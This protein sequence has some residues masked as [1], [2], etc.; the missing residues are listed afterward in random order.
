MSDTEIL[1]P[2][3]QWYLIRRGSEEVKERRREKQ[4]VSC[5]LWHNFTSV[6]RGVLEKVE[7]YV[8][9]TRERAESSNYEE[10]FL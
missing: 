1:H 5:L 6:C 9:K 10:K 8:T 4:K 2:A 3:G 7:W